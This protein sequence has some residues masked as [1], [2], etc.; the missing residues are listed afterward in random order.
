MGLGVLQ[1]T[2]YPIVVA[3]SVITTFTTPYFIRMADPF[4]NFVES[5]LPRKVAFPDRPLF[6]AGFDRKR[7]APAV[8]VGAATLYLACSPLLH[9]T[10]SHIADIAR[11]STAVAR[12]PMAAMGSPGRMHG[13][14]HGHGSVP[15]RPQLSGLETHRTRA[16]HPANARFDVPLIVMTLFRLVTSLGSSSMS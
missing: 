13:H 7:D 14:A 8:G 4:S 1:P 2:I 11:H 9:S 10:H 15:A 6:P 3:V 16:P 12:R 5:H